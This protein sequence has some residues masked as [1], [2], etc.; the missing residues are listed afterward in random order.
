MKGPL[1]QTGDHAHIGFSREFTDGTIPKTGVRVHNEA[2]PEHKH[3]LVLEKGSV[4]KK[5]PAVLT[6]K[7]RK[8]YIQ[9]STEIRRP[10]H[11][12]TF[13]DIRNTHPS[14]GW[15]SNPPAYTCVLERTTRRG[16]SA[17]KRRFKMKKRMSL[18]SKV[19]VGPLCANGMSR[20]GPG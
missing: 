7:K 15:F 13:C 4:F 2:S 18:K 20:F 11:T 17:A 19:G 9:G 8:I 1:A 14:R 16:R 6:F 3:G 5:F 12:H 10:P